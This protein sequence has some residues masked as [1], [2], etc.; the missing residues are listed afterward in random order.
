MFASLIHYVLCRPSIVNGME[1][2]DLHCYIEFSAGL[3]CWPTH[4]TVVDLNARGI[5][6][7]IESIVQELAEI[8]SIRLIMILFPWR[9]FPVGT[10][11]CFPEHQ[12]NQGH[13]SWAS[14]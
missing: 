11:Y 3:L 14:K 12:A 13:S 10:G 9:L 6:T 2:K 8:L 4:A 7:V 1:Y 5:I